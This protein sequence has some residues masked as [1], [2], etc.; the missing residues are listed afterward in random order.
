MRRQLLH[1]DVA[2][3]KRIF[4]RIG[5]ALCAG[6][7]TS[8]V[9]GLFLVRP[10]NVPQHLKDM[11]FRFGASAVYFYIYLP[12][13]LGMLVIWLLLRD[14]PSGN[15]EVIKMQDEKLMHIFAA[16]YTASIL[17]NVIG[18]YLS[19]LFPAHGSQQL[20]AIS[21]MVRS[22]TASGILIPVFIGPVLEELLFRK[23]LIDRTRRFGEKTAIVLTAL[24]FGLYHG[25]LNQFMYAFTVGLFLAYVYCRTNRILYTI[26][27]HIFL[28]GLS[29]MLLV[30]APASGQTA[31]H[32]VEFI[33]IG[34]FILIITTL[35]LGVIYLYRAVRH[36]V[37]FGEAGEEDIPKKEVLKTVYL[38]PG[39]LLMVTM[40]ILKIVLNLFNIDL[41]KLF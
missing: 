1:M 24:C 17:M 26:L 13:L 23:L 5:F 31:N 28:N 20:T 2:E 25:N 36:G 8:A 40:S 16:M 19:N 11:L 3:R 39:M 15:R 32:S 33:L 27:M 35:I 4:S 37:E 21:S 14:L 34:L 30:I 29:S 10:L 7:L 12:N 22:G 38:N 18:V 41:L 9:L 6:M